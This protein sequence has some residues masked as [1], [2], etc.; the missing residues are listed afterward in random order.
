M[1]TLF[2]KSKL[3]N[4]E[5][6]NRF[7]RSAQWERMAD[8]KGHLTQDLI[9]NYIELAKGGVG[10]IITGYSTI[11]E[12]ETPAPKM[13]GIY[14]DS[15][16]DEYK[17]LVNEIHKYGTKII[18]QIVHGGSNSAYKANERRILAPSAVEN[19][20]TKF[21]PEEMTENEILSVIK[22]FADAAGRIKKSGF[23]GVQLHAAHG[24][25]LS[26]FLSPYFN[27]RE[28]KYGGTIE[29]RSRIIIETYNAVK[30]SV[31]NDFAILVK[32]NCDDFMDNGLTFQDSLY[33][34]KLLSD[35][36]INAIEVSG[37]CPSSRENEGPSREDINTQNK[38]SY[39]REY[40]AKIAEIVNVP[41]SLVGGNRSLDVMDGILNSTRIKYFSL[42]RPL[43]REP[44]LIKRWQSGDTEKAKCESCNQC[45]LTAGYK[46]CVFNN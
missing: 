45:F 23:D 29:N 5:L 38:E 36:G 26:Q 8:D 35:A 46:H 25:L 32:I 19:P 14:D 34:C 1:K 9:D 44:D 16:I 10:I 31:G 33:V 30:E 24:F 37:G 6:K 42:A 39:F 18:M 41:V 17:G 27:K 43:M 3:L 7:I 11:L 40:A 28:D 15:F 2:D 21:V 20:A 4:I 12:S 13:M 22:S